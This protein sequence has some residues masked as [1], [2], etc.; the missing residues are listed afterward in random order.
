MQTNGETLNY[1]AIGLMSGTSLDGLDIAEV[2]FTLQD[3]SWNFQLKNAATISYHDGMANSL[4]SA[5][6]LSGEKLVKL[7][8]DYGRWIGEKVSVFMD[9]NDSKPEVICSHGHTVFHQPELGFTYQIGHGQEIA[10]NSGVKTICDFRSSDVS[11]GGQG[12]PLVPIGDELL[13]SQF[14][15]CL[16][17]GGIANVSFKEN[18]QR[19]SFDIC[20]ANMALNYLSNKLDL[21]FDENGKLAESGKVIPDILNKLNELDYFK[22]PHPK[23]LG[24]EQFQTDILPIIENKNLDIPDILRTFV[25]HIAIQ[26][27]IVLD[28]TSKPR[29]QVVVTGGG[30]FN[31]FLVSRIKSC[32]NSDIEVVIPPSDIVS[33]KE[34]I[35]FAFLGVLRLRNEF[36]CLRTVTGASK[37][38]SGGVIFLPA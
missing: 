30:A 21:P 19:I 5:V 13:F 18:D 15:H 31:K 6:N 26:I 35:I 2:Q 9:E 16:N 14:S 4:K 36:N 7:H 29:D 12:A 8:H 11:L 32:L 34:A 28:T 22:L 24:F 1:H 27:A 20:V 3:N 37:D 17:L 38:S 25:E 10:N 23:S 33:F